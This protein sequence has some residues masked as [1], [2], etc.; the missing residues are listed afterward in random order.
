MRDQGKTQETSRD[1]APVNLSI[2]YSC[3]CGRE[4][5]I[6]GEANL[7]YYD[8]QAIRGVPDVRKRGIGV[9]VIVE[10]TIQ[11]L[12]CERVASLTR[13]RNLGRGETYRETQ[14]IIPEEKYIAL[15]K[16][17]I[18]SELKKLKFNCLGIPKQF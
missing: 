16:R 3:G 15:L 4:I 7:K 8:R 9:E 10:K 6:Q 2:L 11:C 12:Q 5:T 18:E 17:S 1:L 13:E 14:E